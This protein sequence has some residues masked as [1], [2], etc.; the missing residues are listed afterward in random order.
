MKLDGGNIEVAPG[1]S[2]P[3]W[4]LFPDRAGLEKEMT[5]V[6]NERLREQGVFAGVAARP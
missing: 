4:A 2:E 1:E 6:V 5:D 3:A